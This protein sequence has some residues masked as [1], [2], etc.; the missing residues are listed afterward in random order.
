[1]WMLFLCVAWAAA[2]VSCAHLCRAAVAAAQPPSRAPSEGERRLGLYE[3]AYL[4]GGPRRVTDLAMVTMGR[5]RR[6]HLAGTGWA[7]VVD[8][9]GRNA[10][11]RALIAAI[12]PEGQREIPATRVAHAGSD[13]VEALADR[14]TAAGLAVPAAARESVAAGM[15]EVR[16]ALVVIVVA[17]AAATAGNPGGGAPIAPW[18]A[19]PLLLTAGCLGIAHVEVHPYSRWASPTGQD[20]LRAVPVPRAPA[21]DDPHLL[22]ALAVRG[23]SALPDPELR[24]AL[25]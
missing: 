8:P 20:L 11:E 17:L 13:V 5:Q 2:I 3:M 12:G 4:S 19:L 10:I 14:L 7:T 21:P 23:P 25:A 6:L 22:T 16:A 1:M 18:F 9:E 24:A 15:R